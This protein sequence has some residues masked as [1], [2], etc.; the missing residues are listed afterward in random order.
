MQ[1]NTVAF[2]T[3]KNYKMLV[4]KEVGSPIKVFCTDCGGEY[5]SDEFVNFG[6]IYGIKR[7][8]TSAYMPQQNGVYERNNCTIM[9]I[10]RSLLSRSGIP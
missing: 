8:L 2:A 9:N 7:Q 3:F 5:N 10:V 6:E 4:V 1:E